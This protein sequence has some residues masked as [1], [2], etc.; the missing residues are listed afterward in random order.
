ML[1]LLTDL[2]NHTKNPGVIVNL[3][4][5]RLSEV[6]RSNKGGF[7]TL[8]THLGL[9]SEYHVEKTPRPSSHYG[10]KLY[11]KHVSPE[12]WA[13]GRVS[14]TTLN[15]IR[16]SMIGDR[17]QQEQAMASIVER[18]KLPATDDVRKAQEADK[19]GCEDR[20]GQ[21]NIK[22]TSDIKKFIDKTGSKLLK[23]KFGERSKVTPIKIGGSII[24]RAYADFINGEPQGKYNIVN[25]EES[26]STLTSMIDESMFVIY[27]GEDRKNKTSRAIIRLAR[28]FSRSKIKSAPHNPTPLDIA[29]F[30]IV[31][32]KRQ[33]QQI[34]ECAFRIASGAKQNLYVPEELKDRFKYIF[35]FEEKPTKV[36]THKLNSSETGAKFPAYTGM[37]RYC[38]K[39][40][41]GA[42]TYCVI[43]KAYR[44]I[45]CNSM[46]VKA[47]DKDA[48]KAPE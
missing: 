38:S 25:G 41:W 7:S 42:I 16:S 3:I 11:F 12:E 32:P 10:A 1:Q 27:K 48:E 9:K 2:I 37:A 17:R 6:G 5:A 28:K 31:G 23:R 15:K 40:S 19:K 13:I 14:P 44:V 24:D 34:M 20:L 26:L 35:K 45:S 47:D 30:D 39:P 22:P 46:P 29:V 36:I 33:Q 18:I 43:P 4:K 8:V 21:M